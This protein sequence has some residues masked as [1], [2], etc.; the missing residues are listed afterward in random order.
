MIV[1]PNTKYPLRHDHVRVSGISYRETATTDIKSTFRLTSSS[2]E[3]A[4]PVLSQDMLQDF[5]TS[6]TN[7][8]Q[9]KLVK[10]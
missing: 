3:D 2:N 5:L 6:S 7:L 4:T 8:Q 10:G 9:T 1:V